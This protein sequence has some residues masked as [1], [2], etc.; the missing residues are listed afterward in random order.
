M[1]TLT[2]TS[3]PNF[4]SVP[5]SN[6]YDHYGI[7][8]NA[9]NSIECSCPGYFYHGNCYHSL[10]AKAQVTFIPELTTTTVA[11]ADTDGSEVTC[12]CCGAWMMAWSF[13]K[14]LRGNFCEMYLSAKGAA[15]VAAPTTFAT[16]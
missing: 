10:E 11:V 5:S 4:Y 1:I 14:H 16:K 15:T 12:S 6:L 3:V 8:I 7:I 13:E 2:A 9:D